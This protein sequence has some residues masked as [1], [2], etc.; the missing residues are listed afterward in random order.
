MI[1]SLAATFILSALK[2]S[3]KNPK[4]R[5]EVRAKALEIRDL[6]N[7]LFPEE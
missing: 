1:F 2:E 6:I 5:A 7:L 3:I 4:K